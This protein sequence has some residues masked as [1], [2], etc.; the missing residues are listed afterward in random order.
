MPK[1]SV[2]IPTYNRKDIVCETIDSVLSQT[3]K[4]YEIIVVDDGS[5]DDTKSVLARYGD[6]ILYI[7]QE[8]MGLSSARNTGIRNMC[9]EYIALLDSD[10]I[11]FPKK[12]EK[13]I[14]LLE[15]N[16]DIAL[17][18]CRSEVI[19]SKGTHAGSYKPSNYQS[20]D[21]NGLLVA[22][23]IVVSSVIVR[24]N[25]LED[26]GLF[27]ETLRSY[28]DVDLWLRILLKYKI[29]YSEDVL[30]K[31]RISPDA[32]SRDMFKIYQYQ[33]KSLKNMRKMLNDNEKIR[34]IS[35]RLGLG[36]YM[37]YEELKNKRKYIQSMGSYIQ[38]KYWMVLAKF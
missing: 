15:E 36:Y 21:F 5:T 9:G 14:Q 7:Y 13:Q 17:V 20:L 38:S 31:Y 3:C 35:K 27:D 32:L 28:E 26:V 6:K 29:F 8:N 37:I 22:N 12:L 23:H 4:D 16:P 10:D 19:D 24:K 25:I 11:W 18:S 1:V 34:A 30:V 33:I 2:I